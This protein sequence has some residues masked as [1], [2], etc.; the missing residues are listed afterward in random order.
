[1]IT[2][3]LIYVLVEFKCVY[4]VIDVKKIIFNIIILYINM[5]QGT[6]TP[7]FT[8]WMKSVEKK[9]PNKTPDGDFSFESCHGS[10]DGNHTP[11][12]RQ[13]LTNNCKRSPSVFKH[14]SYKH[15]QRH[16][17]IPIPE[18]RKFPDIID[19]THK[20]IPSGAGGYKKIRRTRKKSK[21]SA[22]HIKKNL[23]KT[24]N[25]KKK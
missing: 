20:Y 17:T 21:K 19:Y 11:E 8:E 14:P 13:G 18:I 9:S 6:R 22:K 10:N 1:M 7:T 4:N 24:K 12:R 5:P 15:V 23:R 2:K 3:Y 25:N 16:T